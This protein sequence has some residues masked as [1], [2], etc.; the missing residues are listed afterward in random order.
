MILSVLYV[1]TVL[2]DPDSGRVG[3]FDSRRVKARKKWPI[4]DRMTLGEDQ[5]T[6]LS[7][8]Q[9]CIQPPDLIEEPD[10]H[11]VSET[12]W[13]CKCSNTIWLVALVFLEGFMVYSSVVF[14]FI[15]LFSCSAQVVV[16]GKILMKLQ[17][18]RGNGQIS[19]YAVVCRCFE[20]CW[21]TTITL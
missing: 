1:R 17:L 20:V 8:R 7:A 10:E 4:A 3:A 13:T 21:V 5:R 16:K 15:K 6:S 14:S 12:L 19:T 9:L 2:S 11:D 18:C